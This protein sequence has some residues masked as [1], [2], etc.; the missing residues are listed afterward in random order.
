MQHNLYDSRTAWRAQ[1]AY[2]A[3]RGCPTFVPVSGRCWRCGRDIFGPPG[4]VSVR[5]AG[6][7]VITGCP[8]CGYS[9]AE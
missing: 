6:E 9:F 5:R 3:A 7:R 4:G 8:Y 2:C 1:D